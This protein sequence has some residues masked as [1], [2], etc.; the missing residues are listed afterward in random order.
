[1][2]AYQGVRDASFSENLADVL[3][4]WSLSTMDPENGFFYK[5]G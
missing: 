2:F 4:E 1:M 3:D 5:I